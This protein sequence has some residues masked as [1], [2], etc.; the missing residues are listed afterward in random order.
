MG[1]RTLIYLLP[2]EGF[3]AF[4]LILSPYLLEYYEWNLPPSMHII[5]HQAYLLLHVVTGS[6]YMMF[7]TLLN[8]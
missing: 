7:T 1:I 2:A 8:M 5:P 4:T 3:G 6:V